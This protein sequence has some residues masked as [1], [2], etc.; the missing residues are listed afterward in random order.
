[1]QVSFQ[2]AI[3]VWKFRFTAREHK[4]LSFA[5]NNTSAGCADWSTTQHALRTGRKWVPCIV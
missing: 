3:A 4:T 1:L 2:V 5:G